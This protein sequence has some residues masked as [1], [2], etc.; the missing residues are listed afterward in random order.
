MMWIYEDLIGR[1]IINIRPMSDDEHNRMG[2]DKGLILELDN[3]YVLIPCSDEEG[4]SG[5]DLFWGMPF[6]FF[7]DEE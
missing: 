3:G 4:N 7:K 2:W 6:E 1:K 5:G